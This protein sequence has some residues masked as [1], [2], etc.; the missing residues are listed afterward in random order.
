MSEQK[1]MYRAFFHFGAL[2]MWHPESPAQGFC[3]QMFLSPCGQYVQVQ[4]QR[5]DKSWENVR[6]EISRYWQPTKAQAYAQVSDRLRLIGQT[7]IAQ[8][9]QFDREAAE[10]ISTPAVASES[11]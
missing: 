3:S 8:A 5:P 1:K 7:L 10:E 2:S 11:L 9:D 4:R 6:E